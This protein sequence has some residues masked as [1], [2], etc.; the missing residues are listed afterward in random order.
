MI[1]FVADSCTGPHALPSRRCN[2]PRYVLPLNNGP[3]VASLRVRVF[4]LG[5][6]FETVEGIS[7]PDYPRCWRSHM[8]HQA[9]EQ[10]NGFN[11]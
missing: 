6:T 8:Q 11:L 7:T 3:F 4:E 1:I 5:V 10:R 9:F 2:C